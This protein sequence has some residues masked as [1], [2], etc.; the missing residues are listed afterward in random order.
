MISVHTALVMY[1]LSNIVNFFPLLRWFRT[2]PP[3]RY[4]ITICGRMDD[5]M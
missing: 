4:S 1:T 5:V 3:S 2:L